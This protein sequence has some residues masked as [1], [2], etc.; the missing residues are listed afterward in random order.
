MRWPCSGLQAKSLHHNCKVLAAQV[1]ALKLKCS[2][3]KALEKDLTELLRM[4]DEQVGLG[5]PLSG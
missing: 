3:S 4:K 5:L 2:K 1:D